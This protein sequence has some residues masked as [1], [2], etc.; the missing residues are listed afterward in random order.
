MSFVHV[1]KRDSPVEMVDVDDS[2][3]AP[4][5]PKVAR[6]DAAEGPV[7]AYATAS[8]GI[9]LKVTIPRRSPHNTPI[10]LVL[11]ASDSMYGH[12]I[13]MLRRAVVGILQCARIG[14][15]ICIISFACS[16][17]VF[18][19]T[20]ALTEQERAG[21]LERMGGFH[22]HGMTNLH[23]GLAEAGR[24]IAEL[25]N[26]DDANT[27]VLTDGGANAGETTDVTRLAAT[28]P[29][30]GY[31]S[32]H[33]VM[34]TAASDHRFPSRLLAANP[35]NTAHF[36]HDADGLE[37]KLQRVVDAMYSADLTVK[38]GDAERVLP[39]SCVQ[40]T[41]FFV[42]A[43][44]DPAS[45]PKIT[46]TLGGTP[47]I[48][49]ASE[50]YSKLLA[51]DLS[52]AMVKLHVCAVAT[53]DKL[54]KINN[55]VRE[56]AA[57]PDD[58]QD[59]DVVLGSE[60][61]SVALDEPSALLAKLDAMCVAIGGR[62]QEQE[63]PVYRS[64]K[65]LV[66]HADELREIRED[67][68]GIATGAPPP[69]PPPPP[70]L[71]DTVFVPPPTIERVAFDKLSA[72]DQAAHMRSIEV[73]NEAPM[74]RSLASAMVQDDD[75]DDADDRLPVYRS[76]GVCGHGDAPVPT[77][78]ERRVFSAG[79]RE[80]MCRNEEIEARN[81]LLRAEHQ[82]RLS[83][84]HSATQNRSLRSNTR[85]QRIVALSAMNVH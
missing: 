11:D 1:T 80:A 23:A 16:A 61:A 66:S 12:N 28:I 79:A 62:E 35:R 64:L 56:E 59:W 31:G 41:N 83:Q 75:D 24:F 65:E 3:P 18:L 30:E 69:L 71:E 49:L 2:L 34:F 17:E 42:F 6:V 9:L 58:L 38:V 47:V 74:Y 54:A 55:N 19:S 77:E 50:A 39:K 29:S 45:D 67:F 14:T 81:A 53:Y 82:R 20:K 57:K 8:A 72:N 78:I 84:H 68:L 51:T 85:K 7:N 52:P 22:T 21:A 44:V 13:S 36:V 48:A 76:A 40:R 5:A 4:R 43:D 32:I 73:E 10:V 60:E 15:P 63:H 70:T 46:A 27:L 33:A 26:P 37:A 25:D